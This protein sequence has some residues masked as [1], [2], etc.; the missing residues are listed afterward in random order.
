MNNL[1]ESL[2]F[3]Q[4]VMPETDYTALQTVKANTALLEAALSSEMAE[5]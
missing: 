3:L 4:K 2:P 5:F 1:T